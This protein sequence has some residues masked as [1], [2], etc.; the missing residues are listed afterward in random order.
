MSID[1]GKGSPSDRRRS[2]RGAA[3]LAVLWLT[4]ALSAIAFSVATSVRGEIERT[5]TD[6]DGVRS[7]YLAT[8]A[9]DRTI[10]YMLWGPDDRNPDG[11]PRFWA[12]GMPRVYHRFPAGD[13]IVEVIPATAKMNINLASEEQLFRLLVSIGAEPGRA[14]QITNAI[15]DW[16]APQP[17]LGPLDHLYLSSVPSF[18]ARH[19]SFEE[20]EEVLLVNGMT[21]EL[22]YG[23][24]SRDPEG[25]LVRLSGFRDCAAVFG[26]NTGYDVNSAD[27]A[28]LRAIGVP[29]GAVDRILAIRGRGPI[30]RDDVNQVREIAGPTTANLV[31]GGNTIFTLRATGR[32]RLQDGSLSDMRRTVAATVKFLSTGVRPPY[33]VLRW[34]DYAP[35]DTVEWQ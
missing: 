31:A 8:G 28:L 5:S 33:Q 16:R 13:A 4:A 24:Y 15:L 1:S 9:I 7:Y 34:Y 32:V 3:L 26:G 30:L 12:Q 19:A 35:T 29:P 20:I 2:R 11:S 18:R 17:G 22:F 14:A 10:L 27:P 25:R 23:T 6:V 21:P